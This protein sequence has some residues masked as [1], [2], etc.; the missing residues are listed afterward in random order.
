MSQPWETFPTLPWMMKQMR[1]EVE[2]ETEIWDASRG[3][4]GGG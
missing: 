4:E 2:M 1:G 3:R